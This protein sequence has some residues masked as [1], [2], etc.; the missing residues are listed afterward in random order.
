MQ[1]EML[2][3]LCIS[4]PAAERHNAARD[5]PKGQ[6]SEHTISSKFFNP[7]TT[8]TQDTVIYSLATHSCCD[9]ITFFPSFFFCTCLL[10]CC[11]FCNSKDI[12]HQRSD[13]DKWCSAITN[14]YSSQ[15]YTVGLSHR[16]TYEGVNAQQ[17]ILGSAQSAGARFNARVH[18]FAQLSLE[19]FVKCSATV[20]RVARL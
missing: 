11:L 20:F 6:E 14:L 15:R 5:S 17:Q 10:R 19:L 9:T 7:R 12:A 3:N 4:T 8:A 16:A 18:Y 1:Y 13:P 2:N